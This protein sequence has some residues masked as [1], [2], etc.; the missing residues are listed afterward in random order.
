MAN[1]K[2]YVFKTPSGEDTKFYSVVKKVLM[3][4]GALLLL[5]IIVG[6]ANAFLGARLAWGIDEEDEAE[7][8]DQLANEPDPAEA[9]KIADGLR[10]RSTM[11]ARRSAIKRKLGGKG[12]SSETKVL[13]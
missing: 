6:I 5:A 3:A 12:P 8:L 11:S 10:S 7:A 2:H 13:V 1:R 4:L 9:E